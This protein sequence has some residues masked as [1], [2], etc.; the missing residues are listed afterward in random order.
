MGI[1][2]NDLG[3][4]ITEVRIGGIV[5]DHAARPSSTSAEVVLPPMEVEGRV[6]VI[7]KAANGNIATR[8]N[9]I[10]CYPPEAF[11]SVGERIELSDDNKTARRID[12][13]NG[14]VCLGAYPLRRCGEGRYF[15]VLL[16][17]WTTSLQSMAIGVAVAQDMDQILI[18]GRV[19]LDDARKLKRIWLA[20]YDSRGGQFINDEEVESI[21]EKSWRPVKDLRP[22]A[23]GT[24]IR[25]GALWLEPLDD[26]TAAPSLVIFQDGV[27]RVRLP[28][29]G[30]LPARS[31]DLYALIDLHGN[32][33]CASLVEGALPPQLC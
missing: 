31:E 3:A 16:S 13:I 25:L 14:G 6:D 5:C 18:N 15:E 32:V 20:G 33:K 26:L 7:V 21:K 24:P 8:S 28:A 9:A 23:D 19:R 12:G 1:V 17:E 2:T 10:L 4:P 11:G 29:A 22:S 30:R 27:E